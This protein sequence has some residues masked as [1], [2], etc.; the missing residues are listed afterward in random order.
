MFNVS[1]AAFCHCRPL[2]ISSGITDVT[3]QYALAKQTGQYL[4]GIRWAVP[5]VVDPLH[6]HVVAHTS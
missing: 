5:R 6:F 3:V 4:F 2:C 1:T